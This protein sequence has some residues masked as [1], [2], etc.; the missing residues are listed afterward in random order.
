MDITREI[1]KLEC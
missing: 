1:H